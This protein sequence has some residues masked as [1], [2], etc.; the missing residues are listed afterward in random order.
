MSS[1][2][3][4]EIIEEAP[5]D[6]S[7]KQQVD[8]KKRRAGRDARRAR[9]VLAGLVSLQDGRRWLWDLMKD[10]MTLDKQVMVGDTGYAQGFHDGQRE[11]GLRMMRM[12]AKAD[13]A[14]FVLM[15]T[16]NDR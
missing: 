4:T 14:N 11:V 7:D 10:L 16:E 5:F 1:L 9:D 13:P 3:P 6:A 2:E 12:V 8:E 15:L